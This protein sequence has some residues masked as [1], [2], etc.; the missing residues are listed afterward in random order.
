VGRRKTPYGPWTAEQRRKFERRK[1]WTKCSGILCSWPNC[2]EPATE[3][4]AGDMCFC[5]W[6]RIAA[7]YAPYPM[8]L[9]CSQ[10]A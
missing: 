8:L 7:D 6:H 1:L 4:F 5:F 9:I 3:Q 2:N 10:V